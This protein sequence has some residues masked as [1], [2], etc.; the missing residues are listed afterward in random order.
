M[1]PFDSGQR[2]SAFNQPLS[3]DTSSV[4]DMS[5]MFVVRCSTCPTPNLQTSPSLHAAFTI[6]HCRPARHLPPPGPQPASH[7]MPS[8]R[9]SAGRVGVQPAAELRHLQRHNHELH[10]L[11]AL[12]PAPCPISAVELSPARYMFLVHNLAPP[13]ITG[14]GC[15]H[16]V[17]ESRKG[18]VRCGA[19]C[20]PGER[21][22]AGGSARVACTDTSLRISR[23]PFDSRQGADSLSAANKLLI[24]CTWE[25]NSAFASAGYDSSWGSGSCAA[26]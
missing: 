8:S 25:G 24:R 26:I 23:P 19:R 17:I 3:F 7:R 2:A 16:A 5:Y 22:W 1:S 4:T 20:G 14:P 21:A 11:R 18:R 13:A 10:V 15:D 9:L 12:L 6:H